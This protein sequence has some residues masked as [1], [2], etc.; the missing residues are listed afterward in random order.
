[1]GTA[2]VGYVLF[3]VDVFVFASISLMDLSLNLLF[4]G[5]YFGVLGRD[6]IDFVSEQLALKV[7]VS[8]P[9]KNGD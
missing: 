8:T 1:M 6:L 2:A 9:C 5:L 3:L 7:G 4:Y